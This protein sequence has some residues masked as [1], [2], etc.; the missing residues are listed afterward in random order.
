M[1]WRG[2]EQWGTRG[3]PWCRVLASP[4]EA[5]QSQR[6]TLLLVAGDQGLVTSQQLEAGEEGSFTS[7]R[8]EVGR[9]GQEDILGLPFCV[10][11]VLM[12]LNSGPGSSLLVGSCW[13]GLHYQQSR[14][15]QESVYW[16]LC[17]LEPG[18]TRN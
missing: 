11:H 3:T 7:E 15:L 18:H 2:N 8:W 9:S 6:G 16:S 14:G 1:L 4:P 12:S 10:L 17:C 13:E 5:T